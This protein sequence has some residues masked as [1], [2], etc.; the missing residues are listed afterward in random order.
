MKL[1]SLL[2]FGAGLALGYRLAA[3]MRE[4]D[5]AIVRGPREAA[6]S[7]GFGSVPGMRAVA[8]GASRLADQA[9]VMSLDAIRRAREAIRD[10]LGEDDEFAAW[11]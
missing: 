1:R 10:R 7:E 5:P 3:R 11:Q 8:D 4:D 2:V 6:R 9:T